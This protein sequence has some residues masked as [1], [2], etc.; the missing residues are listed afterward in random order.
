VQKIADAWK[1]VPRKGFAL[2]AQRGKMEECMDRIQIKNGYLAHKGAWV[3]E[4][5]GSREEEEK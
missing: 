2:V 4:A 1:L 5:A 3:V